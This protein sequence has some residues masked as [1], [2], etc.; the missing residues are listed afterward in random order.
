MKRF[1]LVTLFLAVIFSAC[2]EQEEL[3]PLKISGFSLASA[4]PAQLATWYG[5]NL[6]FDVHNETDA[7][8]MNLDDFSLSIATASAKPEPAPQGKRHPGFFKIG[9]KTPTL[10][11]VHQR[12][13]ANGSEFRGE[14]F[15]DNNLQTRSLVALDSDGNRVQFFEDKTVN[16][17]KPYFF[18]IMA[19]DFEATKA[20]CESSL[21]L[22]EIHQ[23]DLPSR[24]LLIRLMAKDGVL[25][26]LIS[27]ERLTRDGS[28]LPGIEAVHFNRSDQRNGEGELRYNGV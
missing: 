13:M 19:L 9:F 11:K 22:K 5:A 16:G 1:T 28:Q 25:L 7:V 6:G 24:G 26:E 23:L 17:L 20:W 27:D 3:L 21:G 14:I 18:S 8:Q 4:D 12:L 2:T 15:F 10:D